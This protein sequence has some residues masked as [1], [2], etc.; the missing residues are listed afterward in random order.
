[1]KDLFT[2]VLTAIVTTRSMGYVQGTN[3]D[4]TTDKSS[5]VPNGTRAQQRATDVVSILISI[6]PK[7]PLILQENDRVAKVVSDMSTSIIGPNFRAKAFPDNVSKELLDLL[8]SLTKISQ[9]NKLLKKDISDAFNDPKFFN[10]PLPLL[11]DSWLPILAQWTQS[12]KERVPE[13]LGRISAPT[14][15]GIMF[16]VGAASARQ[17][18]DRKTQLNLRRIALLVLASSEDAFTPNMPQ[19]FEKIVELLTAT[20]ATSPSSATRADVLVLLRAIILK[21]S[22]VHL[23]SLWPI[24]N[25]ELTSALSSFLPDAN[26]KVHYNNAGIVQACKLLDELVVLDPDD[27]QL[28]EWLFISDTIDAVYKPSAPPAILSLTDEINDILSTSALSPAAVP[29]HSVELSGG[30]KRTLFLDPLIMSLEKEEN[31]TVLEMA[32][33]ELVSRVVRP[34]LGNLAMNAFEARY[35]GGEADWEGIWASVVSDAVGS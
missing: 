35:G 5:I 28:S 30:P 13:L 12:D 34:F 11:R 18:A 23:A 9:G 1:M 2:R 21:T 10:A 8:Q 6:A 31:A 17:E 32:R 26:D 19:L 3:E 33:S 16:G 4:S 15:A 24:V 14:T 29:P 7:L 20:H 25:G 22:H 27:F